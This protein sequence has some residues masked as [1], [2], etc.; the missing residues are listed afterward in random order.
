MTAAQIA[1]RLHGKKTSSGYMA[2]CPAHEDRSPSL[3]VRDADDGRVLVHCHAGCSQDAVIEA[4][5]DL[6]LWES[7]G[8]NSVEWLEWCDGIRY[9]RSWGDPV[10]GYDYRDA[11]GDL[12]YKIVRFRQAS[13]DK[14]FRQGY[15]DCGRWL[16]RKHPHQVLY[17]LPE[18]LEAPILFVV[19]GEKDV[20]T[21]RSYGFVATTNAGGARAPWL[22]QYRATLA[23][24]EVIIWPD[25]DPPGRQ[26]AATIARALRGHVADLSILHPMDAK[27]AT[28]WFEQGHSEV[29]LISI[30][31]RSYATH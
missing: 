12:L 24:R 5:R 8:T 15:Y 9:H 10:C 20:E 17:R 22:P 26:R 19:E 6:D 25:D 28:A 18:V 30:L 11:S 1:H 31:E 29:E 7:Q 21:L 27:D 3:S 23:G 4:L 2:C 14:T 13:G 16:W